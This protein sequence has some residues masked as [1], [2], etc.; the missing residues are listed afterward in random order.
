MNRDK[1][2]EEF[3]A[4][5]GN[6]FNVEYVV[7]NDYAEWLE[8]K[9]INLLTIPDVSKQRELLY[10]FIDW[11]EANDRNDNDETG[12]K[13]DADDFLKSIL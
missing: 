6:K 10:A 7:Y 9:L 8:Q 5:T 12:F 11:N 4:E 3:E 1:L 2:I 13:E